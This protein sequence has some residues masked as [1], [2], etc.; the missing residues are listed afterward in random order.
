MECTAIDILLD[1]VIPCSPYYGKWSYSTYA[2][3]MW[4]VQLEFWSLVGRLEIVT[5]HFKTVWFVFSL[6]TGRHESHDT[7]FIGPKFSRSNS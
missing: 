3:G 1:D 4:S 7:D 6:A 2:T 5:Y